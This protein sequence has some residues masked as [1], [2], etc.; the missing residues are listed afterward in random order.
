MK[1]TAASERAARQ[2]IVKLRFERAKFE[3]I[4]ISADSRAAGSATTTTKSRFRG[5]QTT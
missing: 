3:L 2:S 5:A 4:R 1:K